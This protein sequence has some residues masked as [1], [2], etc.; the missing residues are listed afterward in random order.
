M[1][2]TFDR[3]ALVAAL[4]TV[5]PAVSKLAT[6]PVLAGVLIDVDEGVARL[7]CTDLDRTI[8]TRLDAAGPAV[9]LC[10]GVRLLAKVVGSFKSDQV[11]LAVDGTDLVLTAGRAR[12]TLPTMSVQEW[13]R[14]QTVDGEVFTLTA[15]DLDMVRRVVVAASDDETRPILTGVHFNGNTV[16]ATTSYHLASATITADAPDFNVPAVTLRAV[17]DQV[18]GDVAVTHERGRVEFFDGVTSWACR[19]IED[20]Y[21]NTGHLVPADRPVKV[22]V[23]IAEMLDLIAAANTVRADKG[24]VVLSLTDTSMTLRSRTPDVGEVIGELDV[25]HE[26]DDLEVFGFNPHYMTSLLRAATGD[27]VRI[28]MVDR[29]RPAVFLDGDWM[30]LLMP[31]RVSV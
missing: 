18:D 9:R 31:V 2:T 8:T 26:G 11:D 1:S 22:D 6:N 5:T 28:E 15:A 20:G 25:E 19:L 23:P 4:A 7:T 12:A 14:L 17:L 13:P 30:G 27:T 24:A 16:E 10:V 21:P 29:M 3:K